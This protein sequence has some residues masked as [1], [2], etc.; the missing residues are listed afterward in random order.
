MTAKL[1][2][3]NWKMN[4][5]GAALDEARAVAAG[6]GAARARVGLCP[7]ATLVERMAR[8]LAGTSVLVGGQ[9]CRAEASGAFT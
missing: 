3:G 6:L 8:A 7:P 9:D 1:V 2:V 4:G 5:L